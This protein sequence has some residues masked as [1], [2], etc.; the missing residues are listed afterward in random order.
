MD[1]SIF[2]TMSIPTG[3]IST[4]LLNA[5]RARDP[6]AWRRMVG[7]FGPAV[8]HWLRKS[9]L[10]PEDAEDV[11][12]EVF[13]AVSCHLAQFRRERPDDTFRGWLFRIARNHLLTHF[14]RSRRYAEARGGTTWEQMLRGVPEPAEP[15]SVLNSEPS[16]HAVAVRRALDA[17]RGDFQPRSWQAFMLSAVEGKPASEIAAQLGITFAAVHQARYRVAQ[18]LREELG[19]IDSPDNRRPTPGPS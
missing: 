1:E 6:Q 3:S 10:Q 4:S 12:Q 8:Y 19:D 18:R 14:R 5:L 7:I 13:V 9:G 16:A 2:P 11:A 17:I 15:S